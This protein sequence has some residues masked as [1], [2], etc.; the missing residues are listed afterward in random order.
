M[1][2]E[3]V[4]DYR[5]CIQHYVPVDFPNSSIHMQKL[6]NSTWTAQMILPD[7]PSAKA[8][9]QFTYDKMR[10]ALSYGWEVATEVLEVAEAI[11]E[12]IAVKKGDTT[13]VHDAQPERQ[14]VA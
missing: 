4:T 5:D 6:D 9:A 11:S 2:G 14:P 12:A 10:D 1:H 13:E 3:Q 8:R 7:N